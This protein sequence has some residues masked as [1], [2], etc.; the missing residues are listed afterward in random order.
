[1]LLSGLGDARNVE[2][3]DVPDAEAVERMHSSAMSWVIAEVAAREQHLQARNDETL[4]AQAES[5]QMSLD[6]RRLR[7]REL[8][9]ES[10]TPSITRMRIGQLDRL[11]TDAEAKL[12]RLEA[13]RGVSLGY[14]LVALGLVVASDQ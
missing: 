10:H 7:L 1:A 13:K 14:R 2:I 4:T 5:L 9:E 12:A 8:I 6:R 3:V 11:E